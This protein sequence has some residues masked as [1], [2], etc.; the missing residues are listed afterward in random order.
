MPLNTLKYFQI[1]ILLYCLNT[2]NTYEWDFDILACV[3]C[4]C[5]SLC[6]VGSSADAS[7]F[8]HSERKLQQLNKQGTHPQNNPVQ[9]LHETLALHLIA[10]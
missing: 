10:V 8:E 2:F 7:A 1:L 4:K 6:F 9:S 3:G 5:I